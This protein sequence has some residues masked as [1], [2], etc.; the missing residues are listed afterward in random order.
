[1]QLQISPTPASHSNIVAG[2]KIEQIKETYDE[3][4]SSELMTDQSLSIDLTNFTK[5]L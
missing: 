5:D 3:D 1:M 4:D 2:D